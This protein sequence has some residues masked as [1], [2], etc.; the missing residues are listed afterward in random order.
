MNLVVL[1]PN[2]LGDAVMA[3][4]A[5]ADVRR[6]FAQARLTVAARASVA[7]LFAM[8]PGVD[9]VLTLP[10]RGGLAALRTWRKDVTALEGGHFDTAV[11]LPNSWASAYVVHRAGIAERWGLATDLRA[12]LLTRSAPKPRGAAHQAGYYQALVSALG[13][14]NGPAYARVQV[15]DGVANPITGRPYVVLAPGAAYGSAKQWPPD[16][17]A[18]LADRLASCG[19]TVVL[20]GSRADATTCRAISRR[21]SRAREDSLVDLSGRTSL[22]ELTAVLA[23]A[24]AVVSNDSGAMHLAGAVGAPVVAVF[25]ATNERRT[26]PL[27]NG[28]DAVPPRIVATD[29]WCRPCMLRECPIDHRCMTGVTADAVAGATMAIL[30]RA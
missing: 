18:E 6:H 10:G 28:P 19:Q 14:A 1:S 9:A 23:G 30:R 22:A 7:S 20:V 2:W 27:V 15:P 16:R 12:R 3:L 21:A 17:F 26:A 24:S 13:I 25:G 8:V 4:P 29:V 5:I 11:L